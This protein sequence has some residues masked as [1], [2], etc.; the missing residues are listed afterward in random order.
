MAKKLLAT[1]N[2]AE[3]V[4]MDMTTEED[5]VLA[6]VTDEE[7]NTSKKNLNLDKQKI[8]LKSIVLRQN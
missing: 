2:G 3:V 8:N 6:Q 4:E 5:A 1:L 7:Y